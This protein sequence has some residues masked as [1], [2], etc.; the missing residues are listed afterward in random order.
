MLNFKSPKIAVAGCACVDILPRFQNAPSLSISD[1]F[2]PGSFTE[3]DSI[4]ISTGGSVSNT[5][6]CLSRFGCNVSFITRIGND[7]LGTTLLRKLGEHGDTSNIH[8]SIGSTSCTIV[9]APRGADRF[10]IRS[11]GVI[12]KFSIKDISSKVLSEVD[13]LHLGYPTMMPSLYNK[14]GMELHRIMEAAHKANTATSLDLSVPDNNSENKK[15][16]WNKIWS[17]TLPEVDFMLPSIEEALATTF[18]NRYN[19]LCKEHSNSYDFLD[20]ISP[21]LFRE[22]GNQLIKLG[23]AIVMLKAGKRG[24]YLRTSTAERISRIPNIPCDPVNWAN[25][26]LW[27][28]SYGLQE[29]VSTT[30]AGD[31]AIAAFLTAALNKYSAEDAL[32][33]ANAAGCLSLSSEDATSSIE[34]WESVVNIT[35]NFLSNPRPDLSWPQLTPSI[36]KIC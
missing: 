30:G 13:L 36:S 21:D 17:N 18:P 24:I 12:D 33:S 25:L 5:G 9:L 1:I 16:N 8:K 14:D 20:L 35:E 3:S 31:A 19:N 6:I 4:I 32:N 7:E 23:A 11:G 2:R 10:F 15:I 28:S 29:V 22:V 26:E 27:G 34:D